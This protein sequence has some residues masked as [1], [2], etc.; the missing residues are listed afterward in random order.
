MEL[1]VQFTAVQVGEEVLQLPG[2]AHL[3]VVWRQRESSKDG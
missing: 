2:Q 3:A 1:P